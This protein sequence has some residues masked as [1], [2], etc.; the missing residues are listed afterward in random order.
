MDELGRKSVAEFKAADK[1][2]LVL[3]LDNVRS[4]HNVGSVFRTADAFLIQGL[5]LCGFTPV[6]PHRDINKT[7]LGATES[8]DWQY[9]NTTVE[10]VQQLQAEGYQVLAIEQAV[11]SQMLNTF[12]PPKDKPLALVFGNEVDGVD[13][14][15]MKVVDGCIEIPQLGMKHSLNISVTTGIVV[16]DV[17]S[18]WKKDSII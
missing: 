14:E 1:T 4:M 18:K 13:G 6:P 15:V 2:P 10:A 12:E 11:N 9:F 5:I 7:A 3:V 16:W 17:F 8:V